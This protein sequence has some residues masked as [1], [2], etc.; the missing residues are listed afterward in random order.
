MRFQTEATSLAVPRH[1][2]E[3][4]RMDHPTIR[5][6]VKTAGETAEWFAHSSGFLFCRGSRKAPVKTASKVR[7]EDLAEAVRKAMADKPA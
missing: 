4:V 2:E 5:A 1:Y 7:P 3:T 6:V